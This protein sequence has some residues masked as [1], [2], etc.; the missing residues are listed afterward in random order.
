MEKGE[1]NMKGQATQLLGINLFICFILVVISAVV[2]VPAGERGILFQFGAVTGT[3][4]D[5]GLHFQTPFVQGVEMMNVKIQKITTEASAAS[6]DLQTVTTKVA[7]NY[8]IKPDMVAWVRQNIGSEYKS[9]VIDPAIQEAIKS[10]TAQFNAEELISQRQTVRQNMENILQEKLN[11]ITNNA[12][13]VEAFNIEDFQFSPEFDKAIEEKQTAEQNA[14][15]EKNKLEQVKFEAQQQIENAK[16]EA[17]SLRIQNEQLKESK[18][19]L[20]LR[21]IEAWDGKM[22]TVYVVGESS[23]DILMSLPINIT[24]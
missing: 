12:V 1:N 14:L 18:E 23:A 21:W 2:I 5:E 11:L 8:K 19:V 4:F 16:A 6:K 13:D 7:L 17:E 9:I 24:S 10:A 20:I 15:R 22:P 3:V